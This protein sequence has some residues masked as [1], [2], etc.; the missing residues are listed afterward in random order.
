M[1]TEPLAQAFCQ[2]AALILEG[3]DAVAEADA[4]RAD[5]P[6]RRL[7]ATLQSDR[8]ASMG[9]GRLRKG[10]SALCGALGAE[11]RHPGR[12]KPATGDEER[13]GGTRTCAAGSRIWR[14][15]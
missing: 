12:F 13:L 10:M 6:F 2:E 9:C 8:A 7:I 11:V 1:D 15:S 4:M 5:R 3:M 14:T